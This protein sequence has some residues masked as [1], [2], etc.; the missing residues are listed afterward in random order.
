[1]LKDRVEFKLNENAQGELQIQDGQRVEN[2]Q[3]MI[4]LIDTGN[5]VRT[6]AE[7]R[8]NVQSSRSHAVLQIVSIEY[9]QNSHYFEQFELA[10]MWA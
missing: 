10:R 4:S 8:M 2:P 6:V 1:M 9:I 7:T 5:S 3:E